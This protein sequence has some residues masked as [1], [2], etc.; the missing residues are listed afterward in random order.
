MI[1][2]L[3]SSREVIAKVYADLDL[4][5]EHQRISDIQEW[6]SEAV[7]KIGAVTQLRRIVSGSNEAPY[8]EVKDYQAKLPNDLYRLNYVA[9]STQLTGPWVP[10]KKST[11]AFNMWPSVE[12]SA[13][14]GDNLIKDIVLV[15]TVKAL[16]QKYVDDPIYA[17]FNKMDTETALEILNTNAN[18]R[19]ILTNLINATGS[20]NAIRSSEGIKYFVKPGYIVMNTRNG[21]L[22]LSYD[23]VY[24]DEDGYLLI[25][26][27]TSYKEAIFWYVVVKLKYPDYM[28]GRMHPE[29]YYNAK[30]SW[31]FYC[32]QAYGEAMMPDQEDMETIG[33]SWNKLVPD[34][35]LH[36]GAY[37][38]LTDSQT[39]YNHNN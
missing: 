32:K 24:T 22:K 14:T 37:D 29:I 11:S 39:I 13:A 15:D 25:P 31:N 19:T 16:Y 4:K 9:Y 3:T 8:L 20:G 17:W 23:S 21:F 28:A 35:D 12:P 27:L 36:Q 2:K 10:I 33:R 5:E 7:E 26:D 38:S 34:M 18:V 1:Y 6:V 30:R